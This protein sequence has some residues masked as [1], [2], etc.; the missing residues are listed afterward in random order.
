MAQKATATVQI[1]KNGR[2]YLPAS[3][4]K[5]LGIHKQHADL[6]LTVEVLTDDQD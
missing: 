4:R 1:D 5:A 3:T 6:N 2:M